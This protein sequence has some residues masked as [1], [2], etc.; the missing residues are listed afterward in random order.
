MHLKMAAM[1]TITVV[2]A[3]WSED[4]FLAMHGHY[5]LGLIMVF[6]PRDEDEVETVKQNVASSMSSQLVCQLSSSWQATICA[7]Q[8]LD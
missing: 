3:G 7:P 6:S 5:P 1:E 2:D 8:A 4:H